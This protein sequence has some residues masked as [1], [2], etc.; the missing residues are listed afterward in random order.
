VTIVMKL[1]VLLLLLVDVVALLSCIILL[2]LGERLLLLF[3]LG[4]YVDR[5]LL[6]RMNLRD[7]LVLRL[8]IFDLSVVIFHHHLFLLLVLIDLLT[9]IQGHRAREGRSFSLLALHVRF[10]LAQG[11]GKINDLGPS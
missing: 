2:L 3:D 1:R 9:R 6:N 7:L 4:L 10:T 5:G 11:V 8:L